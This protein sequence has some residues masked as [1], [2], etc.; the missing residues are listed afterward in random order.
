MEGVVVSAKKDGSTI[1]VSVVSDAQGRFTFPASRLEPGNYSL[2]A[3]AVGYDLDGANTATVAAGKAAQAQLKLK[4]TRNLAAQLTNA[5]WLMSMPGTDEQKKF[6]LNCNG[7]HSYQ[8][9]VNSSYDADASCR[10]S[11]AGG[12]YPAACR[13][14]RSGSPARDTRRHDGPQA[15]RHARW[16]AADQ[17]QSQKGTGHTLKTAAAERKI[18]AGHHHG[19]RSAHLM[20]SRT[21]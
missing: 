21:T 3:R 16:R 8:R 20:S 6:L 2:K 7:C 5:E 12:Y 10:S 1:T 11:S 17:R 14:S 15:V 9:I 4:K 18:D 19:I 13:P